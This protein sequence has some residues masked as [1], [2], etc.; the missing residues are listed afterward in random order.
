MR[1]GE[2]TCPSLD[3][4]TP[5]MLSPRDIAVDSHTTPTH[6]TVHLQ[7][8]KT[9][10][11]GAGV[12]LHLGSTGDI[13]CPVAAVLG[14]L[15]IR[16]SSPGPLFLFNDGSVLSRPRLVQA[17]HQALR[18]A[19]V[20][21]SRFSGHSFRIGAA[22]TAARVGLPDSLIITLGRW[23]SSTFARYIRTSW[24]DLSAVSAALATPHQMMP[25]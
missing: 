16:P 24:Q 20:D 25:S 2:F 13:L 19:G 15:A 4:F 8:S 17:L 12:T 22:T 9:D 11:F 10:P 1:A 18:A 5:D 21:D 14:Y 7:T 3:A 23:K 6:L